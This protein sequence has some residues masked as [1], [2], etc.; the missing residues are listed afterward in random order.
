MQELFEQAVAL[1]KTLSEKPSNE[2]LLQLYSLYK[3]ATEGDAGADGP[4]NPFDFVGKAKYDAWT[5]LKGT[6]KEAAMQQYIDLV[7]KLKN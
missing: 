1:S 5:A 3:Q 4:S 2:T 6:A 7:N